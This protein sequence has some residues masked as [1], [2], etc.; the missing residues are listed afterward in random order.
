MGCKIATIL[1]LFFFASCQSKQSCIPVIKYE[2]FKIQSNYDEATNFEIF[3]VLNNTEE[4]IYDSSAVLKCVQQYLDV[5]TTGRVYSCI[6][7]LLTDDCIDKGETLSQ[8]WGEINES[9]IA[10]FYLNSDNSIFQSDYNKD[11]ILK[12][13]SLGH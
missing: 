7:L 8:N 11:Y 9:T 4:C 5:D 2:A 10:L 1:S 6:T 12:E 3:L 13:S